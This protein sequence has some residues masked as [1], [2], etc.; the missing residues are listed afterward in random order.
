[1]VDL[2]LFLM[3][4]ILVLLAQVHPNPVY[5]SIKFFNPK[6]IRNCYTVLYSINYF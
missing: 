6:N 5:T 3:S 1:M 2:R 4:T